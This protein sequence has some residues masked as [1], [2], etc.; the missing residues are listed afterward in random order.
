MSKQDSD[1]VR[2]IQLAVLSALVDGQ[3]SS[4]EIEAI[5]TGVSEHCEIEPAQAKALATKMIERYVSQEL[6]RNPVAIVRH[7][8]NAMRRLSGLQRRVAIRI[9]KRVAAASPGGEERE[10]R[11]L[12][13]LEQLA[14]A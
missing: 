11:L 10:A 12:R 14:R 4:E 5:A 13:Q 7:G 1:T 9:A 3:A 6:A 8:K 2:V